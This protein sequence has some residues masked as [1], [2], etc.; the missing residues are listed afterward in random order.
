MSVPDAVLKQ[1]P[2]HAQLLES[3]AELDYVPPA[4]VQQ[5]AFVKSLEEQALKKQTKKERKEH[6]ALHN[7]TAR[8]LTYK[9][10]GNKDRF[11]A[12]ASKEER[13]YVEALAKETQE[14]NS[15]SQLKIMLSEAE[16]V[17]TDLRNK[18]VAYQTAKKDLAALYSR[19]FDGPTQ[20][21]PDDDRLENELQLTQT[22]HDQIQGRL[23][24]ESQALNLLHL[25]N[26]SLHACASKLNEALSAS[27]WDMWG[28]GNMADMM[29]RSALGGAESHSIQADM[30]VQQARMSS[31]AV[32]PIGEIRI[33]QGSIIS[34]VMFDNIFTDMAFHD[35][36]KASAQNV[37][38]VQFNL[39]NEIA[40]AS[41]RVAAVGGEL[42]A[43]ADALTRARGA[44]DSYRKGIFDS[45]PVNIP[46]RPAYTP[47]PST[48]EPNTVYTPPPGPPPPNADAPSFAMPAPD[49][50]Y[51][52]P[53]GP[54]PA[55]S[56][57]APLPSAAWGSRNPFAAA[58]A[59]ANSHGG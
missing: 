58:L 22:K 44:L 53:P 33:A 47:D 59:D 43:A 28:G 26:K 38:A 56:N 42:G 2:Y 5:D 39:T 23:N 11:E 10:T 41:A 7:S 8:R 40:A 35:K 37:K 54:P 21:Y 12:K 17:R 24:Q 27:E 13:E 45:L 36:I 15:E 46:P 52:P 57:A 25:A 34:D 3:I 4:L 29:E 50:V 14:R 51:T 19:L 31:S 30:Y 55:N 48:A 20:A 49:V 6:E 16:A 1:A 18:L 9:L 32:K